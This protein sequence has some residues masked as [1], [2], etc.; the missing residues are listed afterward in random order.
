MPTYEYYCT[1]NHQTLEVMHPM[2]TAVETWGQLCE[3]AEQD[4]GATPADTPVDKL[5]SAGMVLAKKPD[6]SECS[7]PP[8][9]GGCCGGVCGGGH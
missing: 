8:M 9:G 1:D 3:L 6:A 5:L 2:S 4:P 7:G